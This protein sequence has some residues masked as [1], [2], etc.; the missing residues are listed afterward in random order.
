MRVC[1]GV[2]LGSTTTKAILIDE[3]GQIVGKGIT[4]SRSNYEVASAVARDEAVT[5]ARF[6]LLA[7][8]LEAERG[9]GSDEI[10]ALDKML[11]AA[12]RLE[13]YLDELTALRARVG[14]VVAIGTRASAPVKDALGAIFDR[15]E[16]DAPA[17]FLGGNALNIDKVPRPQKKSHRVPCHFDSRGKSGTCFQRGLG[18]EGTCSI[19]GF[20]WSQMDDRKRNNADP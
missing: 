6:N 8:Q 2:D 4:N 16:R 3:D 15:M 18:V 12:F 19:R 17:Q 11:L 5:S 14:E 10:R 7:R 13:L 9:P 20:S 1:V